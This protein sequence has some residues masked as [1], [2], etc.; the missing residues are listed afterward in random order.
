VSVLAVA[1]GLGLLFLLAAGLIGLALLP[2]NRRPKPPSPPELAAKDGPMP[3]V[4]DDKGPRNGK[5]GDGL[6]NPGA[7]RL[8]AERLPAPKGEEG[9]V[10]PQEVVFRRELEATRRHAG[11]KAARGLAA[12]AAGQVFVSDGPLVYRAEGDRRPAAFFKDAGGCGGLAVDAKGRLLAGL[13][14]G[15]RV[16]RI[17][18]TNRTVEEVAH[19]PAGRRFHHPRHLAVDGAGGTYV[20]DASGLGGPDDKGAVY[21]V[22]PSGAVQRLPVA[23]PRPRGVA[24]AP[25]GKTLYVVAA[26]SPDVMAYP[27]DAPG[28]PGPGRVLC[29][30]A[31][32]AQGPA[33]VAVDGRGHL[34]LLN[35][36]LP[37]VQVV[38]AAGAPQTA[39]KLPE[40]PVACALG[41]EGR[42]TLFVL[43]RQ[44]LYS[45]EIAF[46]PR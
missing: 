35:P 33:G 4:A 8:K 3:G 10:R 28:A 13:A 30:L 12:D 37:G 27:L 24:L 32:P 14:K 6:L 23:L 9:P 17:D 45:L 40:A 18:P 42:R 25:D 36:A 15:G 38:D 39:V 41:G 43:T 26:G 2:G 22:A 5:E 19:G 20:T 16:V 44:A 11:F 21:Y 34:Y 7:G 46:V 29:R 31:G 1:G